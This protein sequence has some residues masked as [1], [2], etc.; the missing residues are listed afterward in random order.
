MMALRRSFAQVI[1]IVGAPWSAI[2]G[3]LSSTC[4][5][6][7]PFRQGREMALLGI[8]VKREQNYRLFAWTAWLRATL[9]ARQSR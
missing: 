2:V 7:P 1:A 6:V 8:L 9:D 5:D 4:R 3:A